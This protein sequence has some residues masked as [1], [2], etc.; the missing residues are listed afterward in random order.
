MNGLPSAHAICTAFLSLETAK[1]TPPSQSPTSFALSVASFCANISIRI[2]SDW[3]IA[4]P[5]I[6]F[7]RSPERTVESAK[8]VIMPGKASLVTTSSSAGSGRPFSNAGALS[9]CWSFLN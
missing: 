3:M 5:S 1:Q 8:P 2:R 4:T 7:A 9:S 6:Y